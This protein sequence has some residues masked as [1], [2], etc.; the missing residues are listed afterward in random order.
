MT[1]AKRRQ[2]LYKYGRQGD[3]VRVLVDAR[4]DRVEVLF[5]DVDDLPRKRIFPND[6]QGRDEAITWADLFKVERERA[7]QER[8]DPKPK[9]ITMRALWAAYVGSPD[10]AAL[11]PATQVSYKSRWR[12]WEL[13]M[14][15][16][17]VAGSLTLQDIDRCI[18]AAKDAGIITNQIRQ[19]LN[20]A[21][22]VYRW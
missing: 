8:I 11:R 2:T 22:I 14:G 17:F 18:K 19:I 3:R 10:W 12:R 16:A 21:S 4:R 13:L 20:V 5:R 9:P 7:R 1:T 15:R 6:K